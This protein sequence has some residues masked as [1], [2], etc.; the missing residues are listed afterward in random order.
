M[1]HN[2][3]TIYC[4]ATYYVILFRINPKSDR[5][6]GLGVA[7]GADIEKL[8]PVVDEFIAIEPDERWWRG[9]IGG[10][11]TTWLKPTAQG[12]IA[13][14]DAT[15]DLAVSVSALHHIPN[16]SYLNREITRTL[17]KG[18]ILV[19]REPVVSMGDWRKPRRGLTKRERGI[20]PKVLLEVLK[21]SGLNILKV[22]PWD[23]PISLRIARA[24]RIWRPYDSSNI[25]AIDRICS[26][27][28]QWN[29]HYHAG[30][31][32]QRMAPSSLF[33]IAEKK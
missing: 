29:M 13:R 30:N 16:V 18:G 19:I 4:I 21:S 27:G 1:L 5:L 9:S 15:V 32:F 7:S 24:L 33:I 17:K 10:R 11:P 12:T 20:P 8:A 23:C 14:P 26:L 31:V 2:K 6:L 25:V 22:T 3:S 28:L